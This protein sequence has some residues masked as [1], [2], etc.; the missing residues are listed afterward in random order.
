MSS[1]RSWR[2]AFKLGISASAYALAGC[3]SDDSRSRAPLPA[4]H[5][6]QVV[7]KRVTT[8]QADQNSGVFILEYHNFGPKETRYTHSLDHFRNDL[9]RLYEMGFRPVLMRDYLAN[10]MPLPPGSSPA[11]FTFDDAS[12]SQFVLDSKGNVDPNCAVGIWLDFARKHTDFPL[13]ATFYPLPQLWGQPEFRRAKV[14]FLKHNGCEL[15]NH[16][17]THNNLAKLNDA[18]V[19]REIG[20]SME[21]LSK[22]GFTEVSIAYPY[23]VRPKNMKLLEGFDYRGKRYKLT[24]GLLA[25]TDVA[26]S[27][28]STKLRRFAIPRIEAV[29]GVLGI[30]YWL[31]R[32]STG[33]TA[34]YVQP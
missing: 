17:W 6:M 4:G 14:D 8:R 33:R 34:V 7:Q 9:N 23:G 12:P 24:G 27:P 3:T 10:R 11:V 20:K 32:V 13:R 26:R 21:M 16:T 29:E 19:V 28:A 30:D 1:G 31:D 18:G 2:L 5:E 25:D 22:F 15:G